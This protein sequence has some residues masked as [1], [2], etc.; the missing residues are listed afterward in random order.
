M[1]GGGCLHV[2]A[3]ERTRRSRNLHEERQRCCLKGGANDERHVCGLCVGREWVVSGELRLLL[4]VASCASL[5]TDLTGSVRVTMV[6]IMDFHN[7][8]PSFYKS[9]VID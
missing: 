8:T 4:C 6:Y 9:S 2:V 7:T 1:K 3:E 5:R